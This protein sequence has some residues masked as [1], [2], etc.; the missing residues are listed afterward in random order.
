M[1]DLR[2][3]I[4]FGL[5]TVV[6]STQIFYS[7][8]GWFGDIKH[9]HQNSQEIKNC[10]EKYNTDLMD[11]IKTPA[12]WFLKGLVFLGAFLVILSFFRQS[13]AKYFIA[14]EMLIRFVAAF[15]INNAGYNYDEISYAY[16]FGL[17]FMLF[18]CGSGLSIIYS[19]FVYAFAMVFGVV[20]AYDRELSGSRV[21]II[22]GCTLTY[23]IVTS[24][25]GM[26]IV[27]LEKVSQAKHDSNQ[28]HI[29]LLNGMHEGLM[30]VS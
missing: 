3:K 11:P 7:S 13:V 8:G 4:A 19:T 17:S 21:L 22:I 20:V 12:I 2:A 14:L 29:K 25:L 18:Y 15:H 9:C 10:I 6:R 5:W 1:L 26:I 24:C 30:I 16:T 23:F 27:F 28:S